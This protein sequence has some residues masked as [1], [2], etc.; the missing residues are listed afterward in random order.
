MQQTAIILTNEATGERRER[1]RR[2]TWRTVAPAD[3]RHECRG[4]TIKVCMRLRGRKKGDNMKMRRGEKIMRCV[5]K[6][7]IKIKCK[8]E[9][10]KMCMRLRG[11]EE[12][13]NVKMRRGEKAK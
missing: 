10:I 4:E 6:M 5:R 13:D 1:P 12:G 7:I 8:G 9:A 2:A 3:P 11:R